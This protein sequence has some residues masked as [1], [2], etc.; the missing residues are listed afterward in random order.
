MTVL[1][2][3]A[4]AAAIVGSV[5][6]NTHRHCLYPLYPWAGFYHLASLR[7]LS[8]CSRWHEMVEIH[9][10]E[11]FKS[12]FPDGPFGKRGDFFFAV[13]KGFNT[14]LCSR[15]PLRLSGLLRLSGVV[16]PFFLFFTVY[17]N[18]RLDSLAR[19]RKSVV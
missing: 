8:V 3:A 12:L 4:E 13:V 19:D 16:F 1:C 14:V 2:V 18:V 15:R 17:R 9:C 5:P 7:S 11:L 10:L 6:A